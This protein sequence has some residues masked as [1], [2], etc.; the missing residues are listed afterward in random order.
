MK[1]NRINILFLVVSLLIFPVLTV[2]C[3]FAGSPQEEEQSP[4]VIEDTEADSS[5]SSEEAETEL[6]IE[7]LLES[8]GFLEMFNSFYYDNS[9]IKEVKK[10]EGSG[11]LVYISLETPEKLEVVGEFYKNK[12][13]QSI[14]S[15]SDIFEESKESVEEEFLEEEQNDNVP[16]YKFTYYSEDKDK[17]VNVLVKGLEENRSRIM[18]LYWDL[19]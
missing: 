5:G 9:E 8:E 17:I 16:V 7:E 13:V 12:K 15:R 19:Q 1:K 3:I 10:V 6:G 11:N 18:I 4:T 14:W 2:S